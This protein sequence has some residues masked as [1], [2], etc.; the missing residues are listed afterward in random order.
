MTDADN[1]AAGDNPAA[2]GANEQAPTSRVGEGS[3]AQ[4]AAEGPPGEPTQSVAD[5]TVEDLVT[6]LEST[7]VERD[8]YVATAQRL[9]ADF[10]NFRK[11]SVAESAARVE[12]GLGRLA[13]ALLPVLDACDAAIAH[14]DESAGAIRNQLSAVLEREG[15]ERIVAVGSPFDP[16]L[17]E[18]VMHEAGTAEPT[19]S[20][21][22]RI[23]YVWKGRVL[24]A[25]M[26][27]VA[28]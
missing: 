6:L 22:L 12:S 5:M 24:R 20:E 17:H 9:Q 7:I 25:A 15:L 1:A 27:K 16:N 4:P 11:R 28:G 26:V 8:E 13:E 18:A 10:D 21:E 3:G 23:G 14:G 2:A 19:V